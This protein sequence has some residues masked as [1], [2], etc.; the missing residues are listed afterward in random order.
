MTEQIISLILSFIRLTN[1]ATFNLKSLFYNKM[2]F[3]NI[4]F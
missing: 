3:T 2:F 1:D 4:L